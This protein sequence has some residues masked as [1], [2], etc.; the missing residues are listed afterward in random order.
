MLPDIV[1]EAT[2]EGLVPVFVDPTV[3]GDDGLETLIIE[4]V[5]LT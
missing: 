1:N 2:A 4:T 5:L 3:V